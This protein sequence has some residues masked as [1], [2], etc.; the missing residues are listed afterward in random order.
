MGH[1]YLTEH[2]I[3]PSSKVLAI[4]IWNIFS[5]T[6]TALS[7]ASDFLIL[8]MTINRLNVMFNIDKVIRKEDIVRKSQKAVL[9]K[10]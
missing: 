10:A 7:R 6:W 1:Y 8:L 5:P 9:D 4:Y 3:N 2:Y